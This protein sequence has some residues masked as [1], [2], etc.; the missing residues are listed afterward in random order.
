[1]GSEPRLTREEVE[2]RIGVGPGFTSLIRPGRGAAVW[3]LLGI[4]LLALALTGALPGGGRRADVAHALEA[5]PPSPPAEGRPLSSGGGSARLVGVVGVDL[6]R[7]WSTL[8]RRAGLEYR[9]ARHAVVGGEKTSECGVVSRVTGPIYCR[10]DSTLY[11]ELPFFRDL[12]QRFGAP[13]DFAQAYVIAHLFGHHVQNVLGILDQVRRAAQ[14]SPNQAS[15]LWLRV[16]LQADC[17]AGAWAHSVY[18]QQALDRR[19]VEHGLAHV[20]AVA[21]VRVLADVPGTVDREAWT[22]AG[23]GLRARW[24]RKGFDG[25]DASACNIFGAGMKNSVLARS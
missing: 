12:R 22:L 18:P 23:I 2:E 19:G 21:G 20:R 7:T 6:E 11:L 17:L 16:D 1:M 5:F 13:G 14:E 4:T 15:E 8:F 9:P 10:F 24:F 25:G 3:I